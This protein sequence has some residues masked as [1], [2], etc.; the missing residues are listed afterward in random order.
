MKILR[1]NSEHPDFQQLTKLLD[2]HY[3]DHYGEVQAQFDDYNEAVVSKID[4]ALLLYQN[5]KA[6]GSACLIDFEPE[7][8]EVKRVFVLPEYRG[9]GLAVLL[10]EELEKWAKALGYKQM[11]LETGIH[12]KGAIRLYEKLGYKRI[13]NYSFYKE[14]EVSVCYGKEL[15]N[16][17]I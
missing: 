6:V 14:V 7:I 1:T 15:D 9:Q 13:P 2:Q 16:L 12:E 5:D 17:K 4:T 8:A 10:M 3:W 11:I